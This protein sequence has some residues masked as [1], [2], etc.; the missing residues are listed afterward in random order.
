MDELVEQVD[1]TVLTKQIGVVDHSE[2][3]VAIDFRRVKHDVELRFGLRR[4][5]LDCLAASEL[6][7][8]LYPVTHIEHDL[9][10]GISAKI[11]LW[12][13][14]FDDSFK[15]HILMCVSVEANLSHSFQQL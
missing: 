8:A 13:D 9:K 1:D 12:I 2:F 3:N 6:Q 15:R 11:S 14:F 7:N 4:Q 10:Q 5:E